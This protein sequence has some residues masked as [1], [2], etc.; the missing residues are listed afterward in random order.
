MIGK[1]IIGAKNEASTS[2]DVN[3]N[4]N[5]IFFDRL[6]E[7]TLNYGG[8]YSILVTTLEKDNV[9]SILVAPQP[10]KNM[11]IVHPL[12]LMP[13]LSLLYRII[14][15]E[16][17]ISNSGKTSIETQDLI[18]KFRKF[19][20]NLLVN[21]LNDMKKDLESIGKK[22]TTITNAAQVITKL[23]GRIIKKYFSQ[24]KNEVESFSSTNG[25][26]TK[27]SQQEE[28]DIEFDDDSKYDDESDEDSEEENE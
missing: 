5:N 24:L 3:R 12:W 17:E 15:K 2:K 28:D 26:R 22:T 4:K 18:D 25:I 19:S 7:N 9:F 1:V 6:Q 10:Y 11:F 13:L 8:Q 14:N 23:Q 27:S 21:Y 16:A 20:N